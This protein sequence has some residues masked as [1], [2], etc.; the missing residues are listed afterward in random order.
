MNSEPTRHGCSYLKCEWQKPIRHI[1]GSQTR[2]QPQGCP[3]ESTVNLAAKKSSRRKKT[4]ADGDGN[5]A[6][7]CAK[8]TYVESDVRADLTKRAKARSGCD[9]VEGVSDST[10]ALSLPKARGDDPGRTG[11]SDARVERHHARQRKYG[12]EPDNRAPKRQRDL[13]GRR[14]TVRALPAA[15]SGAE[16]SG[17]RGTRA[18]AIAPSHGELGNGSARDPHR[19]KAR[20][21]EGD[22]PKSIWPKLA[23]ANSNANFPRVQAART[24]PGP[25]ESIH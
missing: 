7:G 12:L 21:S 17:I 2:K 15:K 5:K 14:V 19:C 8:R 11:E 10:S 24:E 16:G 20:W 23:R 6:N 3:R 13:R 18:K 25:H 22:A 1:F 9:E 4:D